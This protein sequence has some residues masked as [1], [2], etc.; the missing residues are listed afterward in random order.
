MNCVEIFFTVSRIIPRSSCFKK[1]S[2]NLS[3]DV[4]LQKPSG[5]V[6]SLLILLHFYF[7]IIKK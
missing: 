6:R 4:I 2:P 5:F 7:L 3:S 1:L